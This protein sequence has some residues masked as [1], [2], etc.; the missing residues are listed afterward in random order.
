MWLL[1][2]TTLELKDFVG[3]NIP[4]YVILSHTWGEDEITFRDMRKDRD[5][6]KQKAG[7][8]KVESSCLQARK[9]KHDWIWIDTCCIDKRSSAEL[10]EA[11]NSM[12]KWYQQAVMCYVF[13]ADVPQKGLDL[14]SQGQSSLADPFSKSRWFTRGWTLQELIAPETIKFFSRDWSMLG[15]KGKTATLSQRP[16]IAKIAAITKIEPKFLAG[17]STLSRYSVAQR[18]A[19]ASS[20][21]TSREEDIAYSLM[22]LFHITMPILYGEGSTRAFRR[23]QE[24]IIKTGC[25]QSIFAWKA[26]NFDSSGPFAA[27]PKNFAES[28]SVGVYA[29]SLLDIEPFRMTNLGLEIILA[30][31]KAPGATE[32]DFIAR[33]NC[34][35]EDITNVKSIEQLGI[36]LRYVLGKEGDA[37]NAPKL[38][39]RSQCNELVVLKNSFEITWQRSKILW[40]EG[41]HLDHLF[42]TTLF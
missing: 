12:F 36:R 24:E 25:D 8:P 16:F 23:L 18:M 20:R 11:I 39:L 1:N 34:C 17:R 10:N 19:W 38:F 3:A 33:L 42:D 40:L 6:A 5:S 28:H 41:S 26:C 37:E 2:T 32:R 22:G 7:Y 15:Y 29:N 4:K 30:M 35:V 13:L 31:A 9:D 27:S 21:Q 14:S